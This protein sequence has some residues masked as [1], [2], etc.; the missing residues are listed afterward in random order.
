MV[1]GPCVKSH[2]LVQV[3]GLHPLLLTFLTMVSGVCLLYQLYMKGGWD[4]IRSYFLQRGAPQ[5]QLI[6][7]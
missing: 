1:L 4:Y 2:R 5:T 3:Y 6:R 7:I